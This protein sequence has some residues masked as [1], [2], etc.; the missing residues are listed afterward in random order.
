MRLKT[1]KEKSINHLLLFFTL[2]LFNCRI[3]IWGRSMGAATALLFAK[4]NPTAVN[5]LCLDSPFSNLKILIFSFIQ[6]FKVQNY[7]TKSFLLLALQLI[8]NKKI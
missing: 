6:K 5:A 2:E 8:E 4:N 7:Q 3:A 1:I